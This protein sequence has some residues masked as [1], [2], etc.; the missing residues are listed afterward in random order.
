MPGPDEPSRE[1]LFYT[2]D[3]AL[4]RRN[5][6]YLRILYL[7]LIRIRAAGD[8]RHSEVEADHLHN[9]PSY[10]AGGDAAHHLYYLRHE[11]P[12]YC[13]KTDKTVEENVAQLKMYAPLWRELETL[14]PVEGSPWAAE[15]RDL[16]ASGWDYAGL[17]NPAK[18]PNHPPPARVTSL[19]PQFLVDDLDRSI[20]FYRKLG[21]VFGESWGGF[22]AIGRIDGL[23]LHLK[24]A[25][26][27]GDE[28][29]F[30]REHQHL[31]ASAGVDGIEVFYDRCVANGMTILKPLAA[32]AWG[33]RDFYVEDPDGYILCFGGT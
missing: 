22:Y 30:R 11:V 32:T 3:A 6:I 23:E 19:A 7:G 15:W 5:E 20:A 8:Q 17:G 28:R 18:R 27:N 31:D 1:A 4:H 21:L 12:Y 13:W 14:V 2:R 9:I 16:K 29:A 33:T 10:V 24:C 26:K 25:P